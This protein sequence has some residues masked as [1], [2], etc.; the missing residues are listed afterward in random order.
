MT[1]QMDNRLKELVNQLAASAPPAP[2]FPRT[3]EA[4][5]A[6]RRLPAW[7]LS[8]AG[9]VAVLLVIGL[10]FL[11]FSGGGEG[12]V[13]TTPPTT[14]PP[15]TTA[16]TTV[17]STTVPAT[18][19]CVP[20]GLLI[21]LFQQDGA[22]GTVTTPIRVINVSG[23]PCLLDN[24]IAV[25]GLGSGGEEVVAALGSFAPIRA[26]GG[27]RLEAGDSRMLVVSTGTGCNGGRG[28]GPEATAL[29]LEFSTGVLE[30]RFSGD[31]GCEFRHSEFAIW[32]E[33]PTENEIALA[34]ALTDFATSPTDSTYARLDLS[35]TVTLTLGPDIART[36][37]SDRLS[38]PATWV[39]DQEDG[40][41]AYV[42]PFSAL[43]L[44]GQGRPFEI[45][46]GPHPHCAGPPMPVNPAFAGLRHLSIQPTDAT[47]CIEWWTVDL[48]LDGTGAIAG[49]TMD[50]WEP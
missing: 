47:S 49:V 6:T 4:A 10:P 44:L 22:A 35:A 41:R 7:A 1:D 20:A 18:P 36:E 40:F 24:P 32:F 31:L 19:D 25:T 5:P 14:L 13:V 45:T 27:E 11:L 9:A 29:R 15:P 42:G 23:S 26:D 3:A 8:V 28:V 37:S 17:P 43:D 2:P 39:F 34:V 12:D 46:A 16:P 30:T 50:L 48:F 21:E 33:A 38:D